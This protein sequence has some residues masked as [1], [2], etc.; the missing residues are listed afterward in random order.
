MTRVVLCTCVAVLGLAAPASRA[1]MKA[2]DRRSWKARFDVRF[3][4]GGV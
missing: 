3:R 4:S 2:I 1:R